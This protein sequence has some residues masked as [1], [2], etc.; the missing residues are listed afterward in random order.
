MGTTVDYRLDDIGGATRVTLRHSGFSV[1]QVCENTC[2]GWE[3]SLNRLAE[4]L[5]GEQRREGEKQ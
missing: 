2:G 5:G 4:L 1:P 3:T